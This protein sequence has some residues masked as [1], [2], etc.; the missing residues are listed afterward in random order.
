VATTA[1][2]TSANQVEAVHVIWPADCHVTTGPA[3]CT[4][5]P[6]LRWDGVAGVMFWVHRMRPEVHDGRVAGIGG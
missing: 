6:D 3:R 4:V 5:C 2:P 1:L